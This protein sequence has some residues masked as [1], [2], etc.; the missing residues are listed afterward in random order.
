MRVRNLSD[1]SRFWS[2]FFEVGSGAI[3]ADGRPRRSLGGRW[4]GGRGRWGVFRTRF[5]SLFRDFSATRVGFRRRSLE[6][7][8]SSVLSRLLCDFRFEG[9]HVFRVSADSSSGF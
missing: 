8:R 2:R 7:S 4:D 3:R 5:A 6:Q 1:S 9:G